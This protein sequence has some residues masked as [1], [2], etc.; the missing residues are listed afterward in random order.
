MS[1]VLNI[2]VLGIYSTDCVYLQPVVCLD[3]SPKWGYDTIMTVNGN[4]FSPRLAGRDKNNR[5]V[6]DR[7][8]DPDVMERPE[9]KTKKPRMYKVIMHNDD[10]TPMDYVVYLL[11]KIFHMDMDTATNTMMEIHKKGA[12]VCGIYTMEIAETKVLICM[13][14]A[15]KNK[16]PLLVTAEPE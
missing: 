9:T 4:P 3:F 7:P 11:Q 6:V 8:G 13:D 14:D 1:R 2:D 16:H 5:W 10:F 12:A 15:R